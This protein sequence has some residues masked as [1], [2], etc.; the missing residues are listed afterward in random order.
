MEIPEVRRRV[1]SAIEQARRD[2]TSR[3]ER[4][5]A[6][7]RD[8]EALLTE[9][10]VPAFHKIALA[11]TAEGHR[12]KVSTPAGSVRLSAE[13]VPTDFIEV[14][15]DG[16]EDPPVVLGR[17]SRGRGRHTIAQERPVRQGAAPSDLTEDDIVEYL[18]NEVIPF[19]ER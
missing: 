14:V 10:A 13:G 16:D 1:R 2:Q 5:D 15:L 3:R 8:Y 18:L 19:I 17:T 12:Y 6:A 4:S 9:R 7:A 11:L